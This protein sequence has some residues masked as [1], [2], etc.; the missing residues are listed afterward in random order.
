MKR[1]CKLLCL[2]LVLVM[3]VSMIPLSVAAETEESESTEETKTTGAVTVKVVVGKKTLYT[4]EIEV[5]SKPV[6]VHAEKYIT[7]NKKV[8][9]FS[10]YKVSGKKVTKVSIPA[11]DG[12]SAWEKKWANTITLVYTTHKHSYQ[13][14][15][16]RVYHWN[17][18]ECGA[19]TNEVPHVDPATDSDKICTC[20]Y[21]F[22]DNA[23]LTTLWLAN[24]VLSPRFNKDTTEYVG[25]VRTYMDVTATTITAHTFDALAKVELPENLEIH[26]GANK[27][28]IKVTAEDKTATKIYTVVAV[29]PVKVEDAL[30]ATDG[31]TVSAKLKPKVML[32]N[33][34]A[35][36]S[37]A[38]TKKILELAVQDKAASISLQPQFSKWSV[39]QTE[40]TLSADFL[41]AVDEQTE[42]SLTVLTPFESTLTIP[43]DQLAG[44]A[45]GRTSITIR[46]GKDNT[47]D[48]LAV[49]EPLT[50]SQEITLTVPET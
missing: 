9:K 22:S 38:V 47:Y 26:E 33:A 37:E 44:L 30:V 48:I 35:G 43:H 36:M 17:V 41:K 29:K 34:S 5:G 11:Y 23:D 3:L 15:Y 18:C 10:D 19:T 16:S 24:M 45:E 7:H 6:R 14:G 21:K 8:Y 1:S 39:S 27:F 46:I 25:E 42:A 28:E 50:A 13:P 20:G 32:K 31:T 12:T 49:G 2:L 4:Y 40:L